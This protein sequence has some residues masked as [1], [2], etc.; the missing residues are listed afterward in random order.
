M[1]QHDR[2]TGRTEMSANI[3]SPPTSATVRVRFEKSTRWLQL[4]LALD[5]VWEGGNLLSYPGPNTPIV[6]GNGDRS[7]AYDLPTWE[8]G[9]MGR[10]FHAY[11]ALK[12][13]RRRILV[14]E[15]RGSLSSEDLSALAG[16]TALGVAKLLGG[17]LPGADF[18]GWQV[19]ISISD[20][21]NQIA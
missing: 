12:S 11:R 10:A 4:E 19:S 21:P 5:G 13:P 16:A 1:M 7:K 17:E 8:T 20:S 15:L 6:Q 14:N 18:S 9:L 2:F 3:T